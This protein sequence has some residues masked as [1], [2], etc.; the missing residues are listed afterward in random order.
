MP[1]PKASV[2]TAAQLR[3]SPSTHKAL[4]GDTAVALLKE[5]A[6]FTL[7]TTEE[8]L[9]LDLAPDKEVCTIQ[10]YTTPQYDPLIHPSSFP[11]NQEMKE[12]HLTLPSQQVRQYVIHGAEREGIELSG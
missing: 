7:K 8:E 3:R 9:A 10:R 1:S 12:T 4:I 6:D 5:G 11:P 2:R